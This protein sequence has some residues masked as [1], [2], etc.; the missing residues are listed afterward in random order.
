MSAAGR[1]IDKISLRQLL[2][3]SSGI[4]DYGS[5]RLFQVLAYV[6]TAFG[7]AWHWQ[8]EDQ[9]W[10]AANLTHKG[11]IGAKFDYADTNYLLA[12]DMIA[13][14]ENV[15]NA[16]IALRHNRAGVAQCSSGCG[17]G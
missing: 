1:N 15:E 10:F 8:R 3:H 4:A 6:P 2:S 12:S 9:I 11:Q 5:S 13:R 14:A 17:C 7:M 16:G